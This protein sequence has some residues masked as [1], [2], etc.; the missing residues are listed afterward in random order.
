MKQLCLFAVI[1]VLSAALIA[2]VTVSLFAAQERVEVRQAITGD[3]KAME[4]LN[5]SFFCESD[6]LGWNTAFTVGGEAG[7]EFAYKPKWDR[8]DPFN[9]REVEMELL[10][11]SLSYGGSTGLNVSA[12]GAVYAVSPGRDIQ[13][14]TRVASRTGAGETRQEVMSLAD[15]YGWAYWNM[16]TRYYYSSSGDSAAQ[17]RKLAEVFKVRFPDDAQVEV[18]VTKNEDGG[19]TE[20]TTRPVGDAEPVL[21]PDGEPLPDAFYMEPPLTVFAPGDVG[22]AGIWVYPTVKDKDGENVVEYRDGQGIYFLP[23]TS[24]N[25]FADYGEPA[26]FYPTEETPVELRLSADEKQVYFY[27]NVDGVLWLTVL[28]AGNGAVIDR[29]EVM[30]FTGEELFFQ[31]PKDAMLLG[32]DSDGNLFLTEESGGTARVVFTSKVDLDRAVATADGRSVTV[33]NMLK[34][35]SPEIDFAFDGERLA[36]ADGDYDCAVLMVDKTGVVCTA[37]FDFS[38]L[39]DGAIYYYGSGPVH[40]LFYQ[41]SMLISFD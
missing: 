7:T 4:G 3:R 9:R 20:I 2:G 11:T 32:M 28:D 8:Y 31:R 19:I 37:A 10:S 24:G 27:S 17:T 12:G 16:S 13:G 1:F 30:P 41:P 39:R 36:V 25:I 6:L 21:G 15:F 26:L 34:S 14:L 23:R 33:R 40:P 22:E 29:W 35:R 18:T 38:P 5:V